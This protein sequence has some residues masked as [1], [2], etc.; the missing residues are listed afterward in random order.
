M[1]VGADGGPLGILAGSGGLPLEVADAVSAGGRAVHLVG[2]AG[3]ADH[4]IAR[5]AHTWIGLGQV[6][7]MLRAFRTAGCRDL[8]ILGG[9][10][11]PDLAALRPDAGFFLNLPLILSLMAGGDDSVLRR[12]VSFFQRRGFRVLGAHEVAPALVAAEGVIGGREPGE[13]QRRDIA[14]GLSLIEALGPADVGQAVVIADGRPVAIEAAEG[15]DRMLARLAELRHEG[16]CRTGGVL[17]KSPKPGQELRIDLPAVGARTVEAAAA[18][19]LAGIAVAAGR[20]LLAERG[21]VEQL[22]RDM[23][24][25]LVGVDAQTR[26]EFSSGGGQATPAARWSRLKWVRGKLKSRDIR[27]AERALEAMSAVLPFGAGQAAVAARQHVLAVEAGERANAML[28]RVAGLRQWGDRAS[29]HRRGVAAL[30]PDSS[31]P[32][33]LA[34]WAAAAGLAGFVLAGPWAERKRW[35]LAAAAA[36][37]GL[38]VLTCEDG[39]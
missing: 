4:G 5:H 12:I 6:G 32:E 23:G 14:A 21:R 20:V 24:L 13:A 31:D 37:R 35:E 27:D 15:T 22:L 34:E 17:V 1:K 2:I 26:N 19:G 25:F 33:G 38:F 30:L 11:R 16:R 10:R 8:V 18:A 7:A 36:K 3:E 39:R 28:E 29:R 9:V